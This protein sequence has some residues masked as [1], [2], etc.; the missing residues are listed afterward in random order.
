MV[1]RINL[2]D[3]IED[4]IIV[5]KNTDPKEIATNFVKKNSNFFIRTWKILYK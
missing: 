2:D 5:N 4:H 1:I 3:K